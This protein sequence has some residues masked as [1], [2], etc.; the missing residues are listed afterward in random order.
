MRP[1]VIFLLAL[2]WVV[3]VSADIVHLKNG[4]KIWADHVRENGAH[5]EYD[6]GDNSYAIPR[7][8]VESVES[9]GVPPAIASSSAETGASQDTPNFVP[10]DNGDTDADLPSQ[11]IHDGHVDTDALSSLESRGRARATAAGYF[12]AGKHEFE[13]GNFSQARRYFE[14]ALRFQQDSPTILNYYAAALVRLGL[15]TQALPYAQRSSELAPSSADSLAVLGCV[16]FASDRTKQAIRSWKRSLELR[17]DPVVEQYLAKAERENK[18]EADFSQRGSNHFTLHYEGKQTSDS[19]RRQVVLTL[20]SEYD[21]LV[22]ELG[23]VPRDNIVVVLYTDQAFFDVT[24]APAWSGAVNDGK[25]RIPVSGLDSVTADVARVLKHEL[26][27]SFINQVSHGRCPQWLHEGL[28][29]LIEPKS[30]AG[31]GGSL[32]RLFAA[33][34]EIPFNAL[35]GSFARFSGLEASLAYDESLAAVEY[36][37]ETYDMV[38]LRRILERIG[39]GSSTELALRN[40]IHSDYG[41]LETEVARFL[42]SKYN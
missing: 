4:R 1:S 24:Q 37:H 29:Q 7:S 5:L 33:H 34:R 28:A 21:N 35:E 39:E 25:L 23:V 3:P 9:G 32:A 27:H 2:I 19:F 16:Q 11:I 18:A 40:T 31:H 8:L 13:H 14:T 30:L 26:A 17:P 36:I 6:V 10:S 22:R 15:A 42:A 38:D 41:H 12:I 20:E